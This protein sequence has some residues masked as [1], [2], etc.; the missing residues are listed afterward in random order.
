MSGSADRELAARLLVRVDGGDYAGPLLERVPGAGVRVRV[1]GVLRWRLL[2]DTALGRF[3]RRPVERLDPEVRA[4]LRLG[5][6]EAEELGVPPAVA[7][8][9]AVHLVR[10]LGKS[11]AAGL[12]NAV[13][14]RAV[15]EARRLRSGG[16]RHL[17][18][19]HPEWLCRRWGRHLAP[20]DLERVLRLDQEPAGLWVWFLDPEVEAR[21]DGE[22]ALRR[23]PWLSGAAAPAGDPGPVLEA[24]AAGSAYAQDPASQLVAHV[25]AAL[26]ADARNPVVDLCA[27]PGGKS[28][29]LVRALP[30]VPMVS[31]DLHP[32]RT[33][34]L[35]RLRSRVT[36]RWLVAAADGTVPPMAEGMAGMVLLDAPCS[37]TGTLRRHPEIRWRLSEGDIGVLSK[38]QERLL[39]AAAGLVGP[40]SPILYST[41]S[42]EPEENEE[43]VARISSRHGLESVPLADFLPEG[44][45]FRPT[46]AGGV[47]LLP[48][49]DNDGF[50]LHGLRRRS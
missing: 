10:R 11:S 1:L 45:L 22:G 24:L 26:A 6:F 47:R 21:L 5:L 28:A 44:P 37:G 25:A 46:P 32:S 15:P 40:G 8:D 14:R 19:S 42:L 7:V 20:E 29:L 9:A 13:L 27:A 43:V 17:R 30:D 2:L 35:D 41:C 23:H 39:A 48:G 18:W 38:L 36:G 12:V 34:V 50:T 49:E 31:L 3:L 16:P 4:I 33:A